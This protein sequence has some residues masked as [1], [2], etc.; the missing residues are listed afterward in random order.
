[1]RER[2]EGNGFDLVMGNEV[3]KVW[4]LGTSRN[5]AGLATGYNFNEIIKN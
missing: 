1:M 3:D 2:E 5:I 4:L